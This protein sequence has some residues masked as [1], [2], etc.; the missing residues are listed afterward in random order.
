[1]KNFHPPDN[2]KPIPNNDWQ[3]HWLDDQPMLF[4]KYNDNLHLLNPVAGFIWTCCDGKTDVKTIRKTLQEVF[5]D[6][7]DEVA[8]YLSNTLELWQK[9]GLIVGVPDEKNGPFYITPKTVKYNK[10]VGKSYNAWMTVRDAD[11]IESVIQ[12]KSLDSERLTIL[13]WGSGR[14]TLYF[15]QILQKKFKWYS[16][17]HHRDFFDE[18]VLPKLITRSHYK[19]NYVEDDH[20]ILEGDGRLE[21]IIYNKGSLFPANPKNEHHKHA[22]LDDYVSV[23]NII[24]EKYDI[25]IV[26]GRKRRRCLLEATKWLKHNG[27]TILHDAHRK[28]YHCAFDVYNYS[29][30]IGDDLWVGS[31]NKELINI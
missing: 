30:F 20:V 13:E 24:Q 25:I 18:Y 2:Y 16:V 21:C 27:I 29:N 26:D 5:V 22:V 23:P 1:M 15:T 14:S 6:N 9:S 11:I 10:N 3:L 31:H 4:S 12:K 28:Y 7:Q 8:K 19:V 17:E